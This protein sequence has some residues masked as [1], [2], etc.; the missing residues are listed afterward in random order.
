MKRQDGR[1]YTNR[2]TDVQM[3]AH[4]RQPYDSAA[5]RDRATESGGPW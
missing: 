1:L 2:Y 5:A 4:R 3:N